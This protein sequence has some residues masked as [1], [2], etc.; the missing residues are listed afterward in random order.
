MLSI[1]FQM[2]QKPFRRVD[3]LALQHVLVTVEC[4]QVPIS[5]TTKGEWAIYSEAFLWSLFPVVT[6]LT[7]TSLPAL[8][9]AA[10]ATFA[11]SGFFALVLTVRRR[12]GDMYVRGAWKAIAYSTLFIG[13]TYY[14]FLYTG[15]KFTTAGNAS[16][17]SLMEV[18]FSFLILGV[19]LKIEKTTGAQKVG[20]VFMVVGALCILLPQSSAWRWGDMLILIGAAAPPIGNHY[21]KGARGLVSSE[22]IMFARSIVSGF[23]LLLLAFVFETMPT[24][25]AVQS[26]LLPIL[27]SGFLLLG[28]SKILWLE[29]NY[30]LPVS[31]AI[32]LAS[33]GPLFTL[34]F[35][36]FLLG[37][38]VT[39][40]QILGFIP[41]FVGIRLLTQK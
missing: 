8:Y 7:Y 10:L 33:I 1:S 34:V 36:Y 9:T 39:M 12:W 21:A 6:I 27:F 37:E 22:Y 17:V 4:R 23:F 24:R 31:K 38:K 18:F 5:E 28:L 3:D 19:I 20:A 2:R 30:R 25:E 13:I 15:L 40:Y 14:A 32:A 26:S 11:S 29:G 41:M 35:A 16:I